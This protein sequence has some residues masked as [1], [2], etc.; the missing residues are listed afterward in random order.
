MFRD[1][2]TADYVL[3]APIDRRFTPSEQKAPQRA[4]PH[5][6]PQILWINAVSD[7]ATGV[8]EAP[9]APFGRSA[10]SRSHKNCRWNCKPSHS[11]A[12]PL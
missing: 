11:A 2:R 12:Q 4:F 10:G 8:L 9:L 1:D 5:L 6:Y 7:P 3:R